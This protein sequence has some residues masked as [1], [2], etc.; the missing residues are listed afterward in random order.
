MSPAAAVVS[1]LVPVAVGLSL[2]ERPSGLA[3]I[4]IAVAPVGVWFLAG[5]G[6]QHPTREDF[7]PL[8]RALAAGVGFGAFFALYAQAPDDAG[9]IPLVASRAASITGL[10]LAGILVGGPLLPTVSR[11]PGS[12]QG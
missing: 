11:V 8:L 6:L 1:G 4:G 2:G 5:G 9:A 12:P 7:G 10:G 3:V